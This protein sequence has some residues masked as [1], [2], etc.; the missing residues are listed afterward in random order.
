MNI[1][2]LTK[3]PFPEGNA[4]ATY[5]LNVCRALNACGHRVTV[6]GC[7]R[8]KPQR[9]PVNGEIEGITYSNFPV[10][11]K[12]K[13]HIYAYDNLWGAYAS[14][15]LKNSEKYDLILLYGGMKKEAKAIF[16]FC[17]KNK[18]LYG[19]F[20]SEWYTP[21]SFSSSSKKHFVEQACE[22]IPFNADHADVAIQISTLLTEHFCSK[23][24]KSIMIPNIVDLADPKWNCRKDLHAGDVLKLAYAGVP[25]VG[26]DELGTVISAI[27]TLPEEK[28][29]KVELHIYGST[30]AQLREYLSLVG[31]S[32]L[33]LGVYCHGR[34]AQ[35]EIPGLLNECHYTILIRKPTLRANAGFPTKMV[36]SF[37]AGVPFIANA[38]GDIGTY[39]KN[40]ENGV[41]VHDESVE[42]CREAIL[43]AFRLLPQNELMRKAAFATAEDHFDYRE[44]IPQMK[45]FLSQFEF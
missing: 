37:A 6:F 15:L 33:P 5:V 32:E 1:A 25:G 2:V 8:S 19:A 40:G 4:S 11:Q 30:D 29:G 3:A 34:K 31:I 9:F 39:L 43:E 22:L 36:E 41:L 42:A 16:R 23:G 35:H 20:N 10:F 7:L 38:T 21:E 45:A 24:V 13:L 28:K 18:I 27:D 26:K 12:N 14:H 44:Y 17:K